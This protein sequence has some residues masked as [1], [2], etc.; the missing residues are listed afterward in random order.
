MVLSLILKSQTRQIQLL[1]TLYK[2]REFWI[3]AH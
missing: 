1:D 3:L 2:G